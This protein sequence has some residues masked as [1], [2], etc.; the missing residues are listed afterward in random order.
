MRKYGWRNS[1]TATLAIN[2]RI[3]RGKLAFKT[4]NTSWLQTEKPVIALVSIYS[5]FHDEI[6]GELKMSAFMQ[7]LK[8]H[9]RGEITVL[10]ADAAHI[11]ESGENEL[12]KAISDAEQLTAR[13]KSYFEGCQIVHWH[14][15]ICQDPTYNA[16]LLQVETL[17]TNDPVFKECVRLDAETGN[18]GR[19]MDLLGQCACQLVLAKRGYRYLFY[20]GRPSACTEHIQCLLQQEMRLSWIN[21]FLSIEK[22]S[23][24]QN[25][26][27]RKQR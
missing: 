15:A 9:V 21:V 4:E 8:D 12:G 10:L 2:K 19:I 11:K 23:L 5:K 6:G 1:H 16:Y 24:L 22:K 20:P 14:E 13:Y 7:T 17:Y 25:L 27:T 26:D 18:D 3:Y